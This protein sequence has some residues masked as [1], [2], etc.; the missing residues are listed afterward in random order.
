MLVRS[1]EGKFFE[2]DEETLKGKE[3]ESP[4]GAQ[5]PTQPGGPSQGGAPLIVINV[6]QPLGGQPPGGPQGPRPAA[7]EKEGKDAEGRWIQWWHYNGPVWFH[8]NGW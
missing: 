2:I 8:Y 1:K 3:V 6:T 7:G 4:P 5:Q